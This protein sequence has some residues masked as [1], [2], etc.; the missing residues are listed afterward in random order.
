ME[1]GIVDLGMPVHYIDFGGSGAPMVLVHGLGGSA[2]N[3]LGVGPSLARR[4][5]VVA[6]DLAGFGETPPV[7]GST[8]LAA[9]RDLL[10]RFVASI[11]AGPAIVVGNSMG[12]L[13]AMM[14]AAA[15]P[16]RVSHLILAGPAQPTPRR[17]RIDLEVLAAF[18]TYATPWLGAWYMRRRAARLGAEGLVREMLR[19]CCVDPSRVASD[20]RAAHVAL[21]AE[22]LARMPWATDAF[23]DA[24]R[25]LLSALRRRRSFYAMVDRVTAPC[26]IIQGAGDRLVPIASSRELARRRPDWTLEVF[27]AVGHIPQLE[28]PGRFVETA[29]RWLGGAA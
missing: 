14:E 15:E 8:E 10:G 11:T 9:Q 29:E 3:W 21:A 22:R 20:V 27:D 25:S 24:T 6:L 12:G 16:E 4:Y 7:G 23:L 1:R 19:L 13:L 17:G 26:L 28:A 2:I 5:R 18:A